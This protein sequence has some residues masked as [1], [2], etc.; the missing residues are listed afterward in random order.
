MPVDMDRLSDST[1]AGLAG[2]V[3][4]VRMQAN[5]IERLEVQVAALVRAVGLLEDTYYSPTTG[6]F[7]PFATPRDRRA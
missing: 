4:V 1:L 5:Q 3:A 6:R 7:E 2:L